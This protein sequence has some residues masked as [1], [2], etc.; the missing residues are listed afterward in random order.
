MVATFC[1]AGLIEGP[2]ATY[3]WRRSHLLAAGQGR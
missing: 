2:V 3:L 1:E